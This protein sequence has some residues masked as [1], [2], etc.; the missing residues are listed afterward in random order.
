MKKM[1]IGIVGCGTIGS[2]LVKVIHKDLKSKAS[3]VGLCDTDKER[4]KKLKSKLKINTKI[5]PLKILIK[6]SDLIIE[7][8]HPDVA[9]VVLKESIANKK[10]VMLMS[11]GGMLGNEKLL[12]LAEKRGLRVYLPSGAVA[13]IDAIKAAKQA[14]IKTARLITR[15]PPKGL[16]LKNITKETI[17]FNG[18]AAQA[19]KKF[20]KNINVSA[21]LS[22]ASIGAKKVKVKILTSPEFKKNSHQIIVEGKFGKLSTVTENIPSPN[23]PKTSYLAVLSAIATLKQILSP[24]KL[25]T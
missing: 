21:I 3:L 1:K 5:Y 9:S 6:Q 15:K 20:P 25:G 22:L 17:I 7:A 12:K 4:I 13:G 23:N 24:I 8:A 10:N 18:T 14:G 11:V 16:S 2:Q 19:I